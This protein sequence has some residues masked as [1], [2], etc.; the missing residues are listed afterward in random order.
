LRCQIDDGSLVAGAP[1]P[2]ES[3]FFLISMTR[4]E[5]RMS[6]IPSAGVIFLSMAFFLILQKI[7]F[8]MAHDCENGLNMLTSERV[9]K[10][11]PEVADSF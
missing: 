1:V 6:V 9:A 4:K 2:G 11:L 7:Q 3:W 10:M 8:A 5:R